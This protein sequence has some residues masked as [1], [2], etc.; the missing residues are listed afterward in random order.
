MIVSRRKHSGL[1]SSH[2][3][4]SP[5]VQKFSL[6]KSSANTNSS[7]LLRTQLDLSV[8]IVDDLKKQQQVEGLQEKYKK[9]DVETI[10]H[11][12]FAPT[13]EPE[14]PESIPEGL[15]ERQRLKLKAKHEEEKKKHEEDLRREHENRRQAEEDARRHEQEQKRERAEQRARDLVEHSQLVRAKKYAPADPNHWRQYLVL[16]CLGTRQL[17]VESREKESD[18]GKWAVMPRKEDTDTILAHYNPSVVGEKD[19]G[20]H[21]QLRELIADTDYDPDTAALAAVAGGDSRREEEDEDEEEEPF[22]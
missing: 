14:E 2:C 9:L 3:P 19:R 20:H 5:F 11:I 17:F 12:P 6:F 15:T 21:K 13:S 16:Q 4:V 1:C 18:E 8:D 7:S 10:P 22:G